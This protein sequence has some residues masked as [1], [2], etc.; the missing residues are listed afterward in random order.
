MPVEAVAAIL[1]FAGMF[2][3]LAVVPSLIKKRYNSKL[4]ERVSK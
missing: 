2:V 3:A 4:E 1:V